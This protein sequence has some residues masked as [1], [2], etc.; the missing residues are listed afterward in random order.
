MIALWRNL[1]STAVLLALAAQ[2]A[3]AQPALPEGLDGRSRAQ[4]QSDGGANGPELPQGL[5]GRTGGSDDGPAGAGPRLPQGLG[6]GSARDTT[7]EPTAEDTDAQ[8]DAPIF[9][10]LTDWRLGGY[11]D[12]RAGARVTPR[13]DQEGVS[14]AETRVEVK[15][16]RS[17]PDVT[18]TVRAHLVA[19]A[20]AEQHEPDLQSGQG[21]LDLRE[22]N[23]FW[24]ATDFMDIK[25]GRQILTW[26][27]GD[28]VF[29]N[30]LFPKDYRSFFIGRRDTMLK[31]PS[32][33][34]KASFYSDLANLDVVY[35]PQFDADRHI[36]GDRLS[37]FNP[38]QQRIVGDGTP[39]DV[40]QP[41]DLF[42]DD[43]WAARAHRQIGR[44]GT[45]LYFYD[46]FWKSPE[47][48]LRNSQQ[49][50]FP[51]LRT[52]GASIEG[53]V[54]TLGG[55]ANAE[56]AYYDSLDDR[57][58]TD[59]TVPNRQARLLIG[60]EREIVA[61]LSGSVQFF[62]TE[63]LNDPQGRDDRRNLWTVKLQKDWPGEQVSATLFAFY[64]PTAQDGYLR[65]RMSW[66]PSDRWTLEVGA[67]WLF[68]AD[69]DT[70]FGQLKHNTNAFVGARIG[71]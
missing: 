8:S 4:G 62:R 61:N 68:G 67:N 71:F 66:S 55:I 31:A 63:R 25:A 46:G 37:Y 64:S 32:D 26:G 54:P 65:P 53:P 34:V 58:G 69:D 40:R 57:N 2:S 11:I 51:R 50:T 39:L 17:W 48:V 20:V 5:D 49:V 33:A 1:L 9:G 23:V 12:T 60:Y 38:F 36:T 18:A 21:A 14:L 28:F 35:T 16:L 41:D 10:L 19:D 15:A 13:T 44:Y 27:T 22:A 56:V 6:G 7:A 30:D 70:R 3:H 45:A 29:L 43:E 59:P 24:R 47:G 52:Y 42:T